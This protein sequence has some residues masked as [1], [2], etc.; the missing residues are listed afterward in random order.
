MAK[1]SRDGTTLVCTSSCGAKV[2]V[3]VTSAGVRMHRH[4]DDGTTEA[5]EP[6]LLGIV[7]AKVS[8]VGGG[9]RRFTIVRSDGSATDFT[10]GKRS[11]SQVH[12]RGATSTKASSQHCQ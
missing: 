8:P 4:K 12:H 2:A 7:D 1:I 11:L 3:Q 6:A 9:N 10:E 5:L